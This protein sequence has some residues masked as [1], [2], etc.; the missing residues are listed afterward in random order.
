MT[1]ININQYLFKIENKRLIKVV[2]QT[3]LHLSHCTFTNLK[4]CHSSYVL[5]TQVT[6]MDNFFN[7]CP[8]R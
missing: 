2:C 7:I 5:L 8:F 3:R 4:S 6:R 1:L